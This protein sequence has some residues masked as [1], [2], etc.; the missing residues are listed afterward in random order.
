MVERN[1]ARKADSIQ[2]K[3]FW[4]YNSFTIRNTSANYCRFCVFAF[5]HIPDL[6]TECTL[7]EV[8]LICTGLRFLNTQTTPGILSWRKIQIAVLTANYAGVAGVSIA[9]ISCSF[10]LLLRGLSEL[11]MM[12][13]CHSVSQGVHWGQGQCLA[14]TVEL[15]LLVQ[16]LHQRDLDSGHDLELENLTRAEEM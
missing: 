3:F 2:S 5:F 13:S 9:P 14:I 4:I 11:S 15:S 1:L 10:Q 8:V 7:Q 12:S 6:L 16:L